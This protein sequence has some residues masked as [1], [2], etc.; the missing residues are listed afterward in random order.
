MSECLLRALE[1][2]LTLVIRK[3]RTALHWAAVENEPACVEA[4]LK[5]KADVNMASEY[6]Y[7]A[8]LWLFS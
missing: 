7:F 2:L 1:C 3:G 4:L 5:M 8:G 6:A